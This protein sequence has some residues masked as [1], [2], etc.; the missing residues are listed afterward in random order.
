MKRAEMEGNWTKLGEEAISGML[1]W[2][3]QHPKATF[4]E[5][6]T[7]VDNRLAKMRARML[8]D[9][10]LASEQAEWERGAEQRPVCPRCGAELEKKGKKK[11]KMQTLGGQEIQLER[12][13]GVCPKCGEG[14]F[15]PG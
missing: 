7:E 11:R 2:R 5:I 4:R 13:Y 1:E 9:A 3:Q 8:Q 12:E 15:P 6:E 14:I 10:A